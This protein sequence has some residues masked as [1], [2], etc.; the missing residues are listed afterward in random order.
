MGLLENSRLIFNAGV[1]D[2]DFYNLIITDLNGKILTKI[3][4]FPPSENYMNFAF[5]GGIIENELNTYYTFPTS[6]IISKV[7]SLGNLNPLYKFNF[8]K[9][10]W[11]EENIFEHMEF[12]KKLM[13]LEMSF[14]N[15][16]YVITP[17]WIIFEFTKKNKRLYGYYNQAEKSHYSSDGNAQ[18][19]YLTRFLLHV[20]KGIDSDGKFIAAIDYES[21]QSFKNSFKTNFT[22]KLQEF[23]TTIHSELEKLDYNN[24]S[25]LILYNLK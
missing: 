11:N 1:E 9:D 20:P 17:S 12:N 15:N 3:R 7:D 2:E 4:N 22:D 23:N 8:G 18:T 25:L 13:N 21:Y 6:S 14:L 19:Q 24:S 16:S 5:T 10:T